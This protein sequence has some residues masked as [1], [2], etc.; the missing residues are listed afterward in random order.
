ME[1]SKAVKTFQGCV[2]DGTV[3]LLENG[4]VYVVTRDEKEMQQRWTFDPAKE[5]KKFG[6]FVKLPVIT[7]KGKKA[8]Q[9][10]DLRNLYITIYPDNPLPESLQLSE[11][12][13]KYSNQPLKPSQQIGLFD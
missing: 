11:N 10:F 4:K 5:A 8:I 13:S 9:E 3:K 2:I 7:A 6:T 12:K 1:E